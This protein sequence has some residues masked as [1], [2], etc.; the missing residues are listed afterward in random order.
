MSL[1]RFP[2]SLYFKSW[3]GFIWINY[4]RLFSMYETLH[5]LFLDILNSGGHLAWGINKELMQ[6]RTPRATRG[7]A[8]NV[9]KLFMIMYLMEF[10]LFVYWNSFENVT[11]RKFLGRTGRSPSGL[12]PS[13]SVHS[14]CLCRDPVRA[15]PPLHHCFKARGDA[16]LYFY[17]CQQIP[18]RLQ[19]KQLC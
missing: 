3:N 13:L 9:F 5:F 2:L 11:W 10:S 18:W 12:L 4:Y 17:Y 14:V 6:M 1:L 16:I 8:T 7:R 15:A 19:T